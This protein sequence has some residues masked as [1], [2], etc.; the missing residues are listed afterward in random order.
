MVIEIALRAVATRTLAI[1]L[2]AK[3]ATRVAVVATD[4]TG[5][6]ALQI[7]TLDVTGTGTR[8]NGVVRS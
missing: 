4:F 1:V 8:G 3:G 7:A 6:L 2:H 5:N